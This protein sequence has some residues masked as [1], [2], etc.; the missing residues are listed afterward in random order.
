M[1][2]NAMRIITGTLLCLWSVAS[3]QDPVSAQ[4]PASAELI[5]DPFFEN[6]DPEV[7]VSGNVVV[8]IMTE[9][10]MLAI[11]KDQIA[12]NAGADSG[13]QHLCLKGASRDG[14][15]TSSNVYKLPDDAAGNVHLPYN[16][17]S[18]EQKVVR[19]FL[20]HEI[21]FSATA[22]ECDSGKTVYYLLGNAAAN[23]VESALMYLNSFGATDVLVEIDDKPAKTCEYISEGRRTTFDF[24]CRLGALHFGNGAVKVKII[25]ERFGREQPSIS[26]QLIGATQ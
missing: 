20:E 6:V 15:Y 13:G 10:A 8:G 18:T 1:E 4:D 22:G 5:T 11:K 21:A 16:K 23:E 19:S 9:A 3:A 25:R 12:I 7:S 26:L 17:H 2:E 24:I 14:I